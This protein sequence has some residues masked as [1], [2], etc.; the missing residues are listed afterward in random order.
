MI[1]AV[2]SAVVRVGIDA[3]FDRYHHLVVSATTSVRTGGFAPEGGP[4]PVLQLSEPCP[5]RRLLCPQHPLGR[6]C[7][8]EGLFHAG[9][10]LQVHVDVDVVI[11][12]VV[13]TTV[14]SLTDVKLH[15]GRAGR[16]DVVA[17]IVESVHTSQ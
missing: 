4:Y 1:A 3:F 6:Q 9:Y 14:F 17:L 10:M 15:Q 12:L 5:Q 8:Q 16:V 11:L 2:T 7:G 13:V